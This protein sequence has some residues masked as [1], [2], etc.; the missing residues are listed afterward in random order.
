MG[1][2]SDFTPEI[3]NEICDRLAKGES[4]RSICEGDKQTSGNYMPS[5]TS[6]SRW[7][8]GGEAWNEA[9]RIQYAH[10]RDVQADT[11][12]EEILDIADEA[13]VD[14]VAAQ[15]NRL[16]VDARKWAA[17]KLAPK[18]YGDKLTTEVTGANGG[19]VETV[20]WVAGADEDLLKKVAALKGV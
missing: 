14:G 13:C 9:F 17:S 5:R 19:P 6:V 2:P 16:R 18:K 10:A 1:R 8:S 15:R 7:L 12:F 4:L 11:L 20:N 3:A